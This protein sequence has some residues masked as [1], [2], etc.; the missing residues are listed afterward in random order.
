MSE[1]KDGLSAGA[2]AGRFWNVPPERLDP[3]AE[4]LRPGSVCLARIQDSHL[5]LCGVEFP[6]GRVVRAAELHLF[7]ITAPLLQASGTFSSFSLQTS[8][9]LLLK[10]LSRRQ[11]AA[12]PGSDPPWRPTHRGSSKRSVW[13]HRDGQEP[14]GTI[15]NHPEPS[16]TLWS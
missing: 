4:L 14:S 11:A 16:G 12:R 13:K 1:S 5:C 2:G 7:T 9:W 6:S 10:L 15:Q 8:G 3:L